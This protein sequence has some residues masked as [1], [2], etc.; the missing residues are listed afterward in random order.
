MGSGTN[1]ED[2][3]L[4]TNDGE[5]MTETLYI[6]INFRTQ[7]EAD[8]FLDNMEMAKVPYVLLESRSK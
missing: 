6:K 2:C 1:R 3:G 7:R 5:N 4:P 8:D